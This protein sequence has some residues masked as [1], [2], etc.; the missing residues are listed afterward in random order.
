MP[1]ERGPFQSVSPHDIV[2]ESSRREFVDSTG[3]SF[4]TSVFYT[5]T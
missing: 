2:R 5:R 1:A 3:Y 4:V